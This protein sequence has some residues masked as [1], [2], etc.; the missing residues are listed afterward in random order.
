MIF[1]ILFV[2]VTA[3]ALIA[4]F[5]LISSGDNIREL[6]REVFTEFMS[7]PPR[8]HIDVPAD[9]ADGGLRIAP[10]PGRTYAMPRREEPGNVAAGLTD[11]LIGMFYDQVAEQIGEDF[12]VT[13]EEFT[14]LINKSTVKDYVADKTADLI[15]DF[16]MG[17]VTTTF[18]PTEIV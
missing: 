17:E 7:A 11:Q 8:T 10:R 9:L 15:T 4:D 6:V 3:T 14:E 16:F 13:K 2:A 1:F 18:E 12:P 5:R